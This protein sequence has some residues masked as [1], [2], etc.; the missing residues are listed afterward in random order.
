MIVSSGPANRDSTKHGVTLKLTSREHLKRH[1]ASPGLQRPKDMRPMW[2]PHNP[3]RRCLQQCN[4]TTQWRWKISQWWHKPTG[5][6]LCFLPKWLQSS[7]HRSPPSPQ[8]F[9]RRNQ[10]TIVSTDQDIVRPMQ[11][12]QPIVIQPATEIFIGEAEK[13]R[14]QQVLVIVR[15]QGRG[16]SYFQ[17]FHQTSWETQ[18]IGDT[19]RYWGRKPMEQGLGQWW[20]NQ[21][22]GG[23]IR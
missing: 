10:R 21:M 8:S 12:L 5:N 6:W 16:K 18:Q 17:K 14:P 3:M 22:R 4:R 7:Q 20:T 19:N 13:V 11:V 15:F 2:D 23:G 9:R 1:E